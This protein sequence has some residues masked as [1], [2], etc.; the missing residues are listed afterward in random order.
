MANTCFTTYKCVS[1][2]SKDVKKLYKTLQRMEKRKTPI[3]KNSWYDPK[4]WLGCLVKA[5]GGDP[6][7]VYC[8]GMVTFF[9]YDNDVLTIDTETAWGEMSETRHFIESCYPGMKIYYCE[10]ESGCEVYNTNDAEGQFFDNRF[11]LDN[12]GDIDEP[13]YESIEKAAEAVSEIVGHEVKP[14][15]DAINEAL[16]NYQE[17][18]DVWYSFHEY[19]VCDD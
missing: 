3:A 19:T 6:E 10:E 15:V 16:E 11:F 4:M 9:D 7:K 17:E 5:L 8:R 14:T 18:N 2:N 13:Y 12:E 1:D